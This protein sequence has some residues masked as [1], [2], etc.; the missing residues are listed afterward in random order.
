[1]TISN[2]T[3]QQA[4]TAIVETVQKKAVDKVF[5]FTRLNKE[6]AQRGRCTYI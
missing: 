1:M 5:Q 2:Y 6:R 4:P 3:I